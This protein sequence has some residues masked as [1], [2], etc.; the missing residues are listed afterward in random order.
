MTAPRS[1]P[2]PRKKKR[3]NRVS[4]DHWA[5][6]ATKWAMILVVVLGLG[7]QILIALVGIIRGDFPKDDILGQ[8][9]TYPFFQPPFWLLWIPALLMLAAAILSMGKDK[10]EPL[11]FFPARWEIAGLAFTGWVITAESAFAYGGPQAMIVLWAS[12]PWLLAMVLLAVRGTW[13]LIREIWEVWG[14]GRKA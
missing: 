3:K 10:P 1:K 9:D 6:W 8:T 5:A 2:R 7:P 12:A 11:W 13:G 4:V 14:P